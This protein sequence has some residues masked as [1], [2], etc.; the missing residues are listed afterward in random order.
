VVSREHGVWEQAWLAS[1]LAFTG[2]FVDAI[3]Y[4]V[5][6]HLFTA[7]MSGNSA[8]AGLSFGAGDW[9]EAWHRLFPIPVFLLGVVLGATLSELL[10]RRGVRSAFSV[11]L[12]L[13]AAL[14]ILFLGLGL[15]IFRE[16]GLDRQESWS[17]YLLAAL[18]ALAMGAQNATL[19]RVGQ[20]GV[21]TTFV[22]GM[23]ADS[24]E[25]IVKFGFW[26]HDHWVGREAN[27]GDRVRAGWFWQPSLHRAAL[28][29]GLWIVYVFGAISGAW[30]IFHWGLLALVLPIGCL[31]IVIARDWV[32]PIIPPSD[33]RPST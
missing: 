5:L 12:G 27:P 21:R 2:G 24:A 26:L 29:L 11:A 28:W 13:E 3:G 9:A 7:H 19:R 31:G 33:E 16:G 17:F 6:F 23:L 32:R 10:A 14:L 18:P 22:T 20:T 8:A 25:E 4:L 15:L 1:L 30:L